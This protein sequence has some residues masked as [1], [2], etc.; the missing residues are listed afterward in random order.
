M[1][2]KLENAQQVMRALSSETRLKILQIA[3][4]N[5]TMTNKKDIWQAKYTVQ[6]AEELDMSEAN[7]SAQINILKEAGLVD[8]KY[9]PGRHGVR[10][11]PI[12]NVDQIEVKM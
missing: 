8:K 1:K 10:V 2:L 6:I 5:R 7:V 3:L 11:I 9:L 12:S 4:A